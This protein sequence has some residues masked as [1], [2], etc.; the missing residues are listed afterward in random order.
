[1]NIDGN[2]DKKEQNNQDKQNSKFPQGNWNFSK[3]TWIIVI[4]LILLPFFNIMLM[5][6]GGDVISYTRFKE[7]VRSERVS[8]VVM[9]KDTING[10]LNQTTTVDGTQIDS[11]TTYLPA[12]GDDELLKIMEQQ[13]VN[14]VTKS[15]NQ[16]G[17]WEILG[18]LLPLLILVWLGFFMWKSMRARGQNMFSV[19]ENKARLYDK[20]TVKTTFEDVAGLDNEREEIM[21][22]VDY[23]KNPEQYE[24]LGA[25][26]SRGVLMVGPPG[27]GKT[28]IARAIAGEAEVPFYSTS[29]SDFMEMFVGV[30]AS[31][32]RNMF[33]D[34]KKNS[35]S[36][37]FIDELDSI[38]RHR[39]AGLGGG[40]DE[41]EQTLNQL[42]S[43]MDGF[44]QHESTIIIAATN[45]P[46]ILDPALKR[47][48][49][50]DREITINLPTLEDREKILQV[51]AKKHPIGKTVKLG[52]VAR[53]T[54]G[55]SGADLENLLNVGAQLAARK[56]QTTLEQENIDNARDIILLGLT[57]SGMKLSEEEKR[58][59]AYH[60]AGHTLVAY[61]LPNTDPIH[62]VTIIPR[63]RAMGVTHQLPAQ[64]HYIYHKKQLED[65][66][67][68]MLGGRAAEETVYKSSTT[69]A[70][71]DLQTASQ[72]ARK[73]VT[74]WGMSDV[75]GKI[76]L[77]DESGNVFL[78]EELARGKQYSEQTAREV[79]M[80]M[81]EILEHAYSRSRDILTSERAALE[82]LVEALMEREEINGKEVDAIVR[83]AM[84]REPADTE[85]PSDSGE[86]AESDSDTST[87]NEAP[88]E[89]GESGG[90]AEADK[91][92]S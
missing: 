47:P 67:S 85:T 2:K 16:R 42:L 66:I 20:T 73:M 27:S 58:L 52:E 45:R 72:M 26:P 29:G 1:M 5:Q 11:F 28:L 8:R 53:G 76:H 43:E 82:A 3:F 21:D 24:K 64:D 59:I 32:V 9:E 46:D 39:G 7:L 34:A 44:E 55:F 69:G 60:E 57:R 35:P 90:G 50:F 41:R 30:G 74:S 91:D 22:I 17:F 38:G 89:S 78:G 68:V 19:G 13:G 49:R 75:L 86:P 25:R 83:E 37:I 77:Q 63:G 4:L 61:E 48:G 81:R 36:I 51:H 79:D 56:K 62:K 18:S 33:N 23:L 15:A 70:E 10:T 65:R 80:E 71:N 84:G 54:P 12:T 40:H 87:D 14:V 88:A 92:N 31:R 6:Q